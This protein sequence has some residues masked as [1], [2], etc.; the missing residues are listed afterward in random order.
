M[1]I[2]LSS[3]SSD[4]TVNHPLLL[5]TGS[6]NPLPT[7]GTIK[8]FNVTICELLNTATSRNNTNGINSGNVLGDFREEDVVS[9]WPIFNT[10]FKALIP[11]TT[12]DNVI[13]LEHGCE[14]FTL[15]IHYVIPSFTRFVR[16]VYIICADDEGHFQAPEGVD[17]S[18][19]GACQRIATGVRLLQTFTASKLAEHGFGAKTFMLERDLFPEQPSCHVFR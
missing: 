9:Y 14:E 8:V 7:Q 1:P 2:E 5:L 3:H 10:N 4:E 16:P 13:L 11:L 15:H 12:G 6:V 18:V 19:A 17:C